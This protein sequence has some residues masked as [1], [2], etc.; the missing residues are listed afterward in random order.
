LPA[1]SIISVSLFVIPL[2]LT[3]TLD[4]SNNVY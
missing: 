4:N 3:D 2:L 1:D